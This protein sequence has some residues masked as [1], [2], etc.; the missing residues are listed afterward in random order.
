MRRQTKR[1]E[2]AAEGKVLAARSVR[3]RGSL[4]AVL[5]FLAGGAMHFQRLRSSSSSTVYQCRRL[6]WSL[7]CA[8]AFRTLM[9]STRRPPF[10]VRVLV[11]DFWAIRM[12][13]RRLP[14]SF[15][16]VLHALTRLTLHRS[17][18]SVHLSSMRA[19]RGRGS[20]MIDRLKMTNR[21]SKRTQFAL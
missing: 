9:S 6:Q 20:K 7:L 14:S 15:L 21:A 19:R 5:G 17:M 2:N 8:F 3:A 18:L 11:V 1:E 10:G 12:H 4:E 13:F 16:G